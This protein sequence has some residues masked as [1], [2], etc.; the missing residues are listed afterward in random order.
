MERLGGPRAPPVSTPRDTKALTVTHSLTLASGTLALLDLADVPEDVAERLATRGAIVAT[1]TDPGTYRVAD[2]GDGVLVR[3]ASLTSTLATRARRLSVVAGVAVLTLAG[4]QLYAAASPPDIYVTPLGT[5]VYVDESGVT[6]KAPASS[7][8]VEAVKVNHETAANVPAPLRTDAPGKA[9]DA[10]AVGLR[11][12]STAT[13][14]HG[15]GKGTPQ[16]A[17]HATLRP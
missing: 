16:G 5:T 2:H 14:E 15:N 9:G 11:E 8:L 6:F 17:P 10:P 1:H 3:P 13:V 4:Q 12:H 7:T